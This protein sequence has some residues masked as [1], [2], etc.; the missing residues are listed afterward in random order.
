MGR[1]SP[2]KHITGKYPW[3]LTASLTRV[4][5]MN[6]HPRTGQWVSGAGPRPGFCCQL[7]FWTDDGTQG[8]GALVVL[9]LH[10]WFT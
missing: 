10:N 2:T 4:K 1:P 6:A 5:V 7:H 8:G 9:R 3:N